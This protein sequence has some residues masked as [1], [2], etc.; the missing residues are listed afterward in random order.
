VGKTLLILQDP[1]AT[2]LL[3]R[4][5]AMT[6]APHPRL[7]LLVDLELARLRDG[8]VDQAIALLLEGSHLALERG[9]GGFARWRLREG[10]AA[11]APA[12][13]AP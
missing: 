3:E 13:R 7:G 5:L 4:A 6:T 2:E 1:A 11:L 8:D 10:R 12:A 9:I